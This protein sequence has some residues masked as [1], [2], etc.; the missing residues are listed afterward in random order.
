MEIQY[1]ILTQI[2]ALMC[3]FGLGMSFSLLGSI[4]VKLMPRLKIDQSK[5]GT[6]ISAFMFTC[7]LASLVMGVV[8]DKIGY[9][10]VAVFGFIATA[11]CIFIL[12][13]GKT[14][15]SCLVPCLLLGFGAMALN[16]A[17]NTLI[18]SIL[19]KGANPAAASNMGNVFFGLGLFLTPLVVS[20]LFKKVSYEKAV[21]A[22]GVIVL[23]PVVVAIL[24][25]YPSASAGFAIG[26]AVA[27]L[28]EPVVLIAA[29][30]LFCYISLESSFCN[31][32]A[33][34]GKEVLSK[35]VEGDT[36]VF[37]SHGQRLLS[38]FAI[39][40]MAGRLG[41]SF[42][43]VI[44]TYG[45]WFI[46]GA[47][48]IIAVIILAMSVGKKSWMW[49][50]A[51]LSGLAFAPCFPT[52]VGVTAS[53]HPENFGSVFGIIFA[54]GLLGGVFVPKTIGKLAEGSSIQ[55][56]IKLLVPACVLLVVF[57]IILGRMKAAAAG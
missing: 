49:V 10:P 35:G 41:A 5:F 36:S 31:W 14:F 56:S 17:G 20:F 46:A 6:M 24:A 45:G 11:A 32:L 55:K 34:Y 37:D 39:A 44:T 42:I 22:L 28:K 26:D 50:L 25:I 30:A 2:V 48:V 38:V 51:V 3:V 13:Y 29:L 9:K 21:A 43:P 23:L 18:P 47:A 40:M 57:A 7:L 12:A 33:P 8:V 15:V 53:K 52:I 54:I 4:G 19:Y 1:N 27:L 16:T